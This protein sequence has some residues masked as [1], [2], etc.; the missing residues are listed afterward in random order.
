MARVCLVLSSGFPCLGVAPIRAYSLLAVAFLAAIFGSELPSANAETEHELAAIGRVNVAGYRHRRQCTATLV[1]PTVAL[2]AKHCLR[3][4]T[5]PDLTAP[6]SVHLLLGYNRGAW[7]EHHR[8]S[9][10]VIP[11]LPR[12]EADVALLHLAVAS[13]IPPL[14]ICDGEITNDTKAIQA[15]YGVDRAH[16]LS[17]DD[18][19][20]LIDRQPDGRWRHDCR[21][22]FGES[23]GPI[24]IPNG[25][26]WC[27]AAVISGY[28]RDF[29]VA[30]PLSRMR[31]W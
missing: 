4:F 3:S 25:R 7:K 23:G 31:G 1:T 26:S 5:S 19:C 9:A 30:E 14:T 28:T 16:V 18:R 8:V 13:S 21:R 27:I 6:N 29:N 15:G 2:T 12:I 17:V 10:I 22:T 11:D 20:R 24:L